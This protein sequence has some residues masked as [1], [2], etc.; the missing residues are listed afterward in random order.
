[1]EAADTRVLLMTEV[2]IAFVRPELLSMNDRRE[3][4]NRGSGERD[5]VAQ[6]RDTAYY[7]WVQAFPATG[8]RGRA[9]PTPADVYVL[10]EVN[11]NRRR[12]PHNF[13]PTIKAIVDGLTR[14]GAWP[15]DN[16]E[17]VRTHEPEILVTDTRHPQCYVRVVS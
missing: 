12:D 13:Y 7:A 17:H 8:P 16:A 3:R 5:L 9:V 4:F 2:N 11:T 6:W 14:A 1:M 15:D 10:L